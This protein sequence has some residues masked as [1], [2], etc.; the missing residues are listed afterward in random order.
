[1]ASRKHAL[2]YQAAT[3][4]TIAIT[5]TTSGPDTGESDQRETRYTNEANRE[6][7]EPSSAPNPPSTHMESPTQGEMR[8]VLVGKT[9]VGKSASGNTILGREEFESEINPS[10][11]TA[12]CLKKRGIVDGRELYV[13]DTPGLFD[14]NYSKAEIITEI[15]KCISLASPGP[16]VFLVTIQ[17]GRFTQEEQETVRLIQKI[18]GRESGKYTMILFTHGDRLKRKKI[19]EFISKS[20]ELADFTDQCRGRYHVFN[21]Y[22]DPDNHAQVTQLLQKIDN[23]VTMNGGGY[24]TTEMFQYV[25]AEIEREKEKILQEI[26]ERARAELERQLKDKAKVEQALEELTK[27]NEKMAREKA[28]LNNAFIRKCSA[29]G[30]GVGAIAGG[31][32]GGLIGI[33]G[34]PVG[35][36]AGI[37]LGSAGG[38][39]IGAGIGA[40]AG[41]ATK[42]TIQ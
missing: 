8:I 4:E 38:A 39:G 27:E 15:A 35:I 7:P 40:G 14:T 24:Y 21:N 30:A 37:A 2:F 28:E 12:Q 23:M 5:T 26:R 42:C 10:S 33:I 22:E 13:I 1:M 18:F 9:G 41:A 29:T 17:L 11:V 16:H 32:V 20:K 19:E 6:V 3:S 36:I 34:G 31:I 25:E